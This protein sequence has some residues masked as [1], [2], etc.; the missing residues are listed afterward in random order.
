M[1][2]VGWRNWV[3]KTTMWTCILS[4]RSYLSAT[5]ETYCPY[6]TH[7]GTGRLFPPRL[8][9]H[10]LAQVASDFYIWEWRE[11]EMPEPQ[12]FR[13]SLKSFRIFPSWWIHGLQNCFQNEMTEVG[14][15]GHVWK[16]SQCPT[17][18]NWFMNKDEEVR[19]AGRNHLSII[20]LGKLK[21]DAALT[22]EWVWKGDL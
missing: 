19:C 15:I 7:L 16:W 11:A 17:E 4:P 20:C 6:S 14:D 10:F 22:A 13:H 21:D 2:E 12:K 9:H 5:T 1:N 3:L 8:T 18:I